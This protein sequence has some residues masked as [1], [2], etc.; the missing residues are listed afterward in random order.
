MRYFVIT[1]VRKANG[2]IDEQCEVTKRLKERDLTTAN[3]IL[4]FKEKKIE[5]CLIEGQVL[6]MEWDKAYDYYKRAYPAIIERLEQEAA[7]E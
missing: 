6:T 3:V 5:K 7:Q 2:Q 4:D 1:Y